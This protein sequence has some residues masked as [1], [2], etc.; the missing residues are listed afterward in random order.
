MTRLMTSC[1]LAALLALSTGCDALNQAVTGLLGG[2]DSEPANPLLRESKV[3]ILTVGDVESGVMNSLAN[4]TEF[5]AYAGQSV[6]D[7]A[8][9]LFDGDSLDADTLREHEMVTAALAAGVPVIVSEPALDHNQRFV[10]ELT[11]MSPVEQRAAI[12][13]DKVSD[14][15]G[16]SHWAIIE[17]GAAPDDLLVEGDEAALDDEQH[18]FAAAVLDYLEAGEFEMKQNIDSQAAVVS[19]PRSTALD[20]GDASLAPQAG[21]KFKHIYQVLSGRATGLT[22]TLQV[23]GTPPFSQLNIQLT[24]SGAVAA[25]LQA[26]FAP[27]SPSH[28]LT[29]SWYIYHNDGENPSDDFAGQDCFVAILHQRGTFS[30]GPS[31][32]AQRGPTLGYFHDILTIRNTPFTYAAG[33]TSGL[34]PITLTL[35]ETSPTNVNQVTHQESSHSTSTT[36]TLSFGIS[37]SGVMAGG[38]IA[39]T[40]EVGFSVSRDISDWGIL[41]LSDPGTSASAWIFHQQSPCDPYMGDTTKC[42][43]GN[44]PNDVPALSQGTN[45]QDTVTVWTT[46]G[47]APSDTATNTYRLAF[48]T[49]VSQ[50][51]RLLTTPT[52]I[53]NLLSLSSSLPTRMNVALTSTNTYAIEL[54][55]QF[56]TK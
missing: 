5:E 34:S 2:D 40:N 44:T 32:P 8:A 41:N 31:G 30:V 19:K 35:D 22:P 39:K 38:A 37:S 20:N 50:S 54:N 33:N 1:G 9:V 13:I 53:L 17:G 24:N 28:Q 47:V 26:Y 43:T 55:D 56:F 15:T 25:N 48:K 45:V 52:Y 42:F 12:L 29:N 27:Q 14:S 46:I 23:L 51:M 7:F 3:R 10:H 49:D 16:R 18:Y 6:G 36:K 11:G 4:F 21:A